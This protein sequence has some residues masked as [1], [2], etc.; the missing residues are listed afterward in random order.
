MREGLGLEGWMGERSSLTSKAGERREPP[1][2]R[3]A[4]EEREDLMGT[5][6]VP[7]EETA[8]A[9]GLGMGPEMRSDP[10]FVGCPLRCFVNPTTEKARLRPVG[11]LGAATI[12]STVGLKKLRRAV[13]RDGLCV[14]RPSADP[15]LLIPRE[16]SCWPTE[17]CAEIWMRC[18][19]EK[20]TVL[21]CAD[22][23]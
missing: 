20:E 2:E 13:D 5:E 19:D 17:G 12:G 21:L 7:E 10:A 6:K 18:W 16:P 23:S 3:R 9:G 15:R 14:G 1:E 22:A 8:W 11:L 4:A